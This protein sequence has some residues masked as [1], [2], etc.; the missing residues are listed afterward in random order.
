M[1]NR[2]NIDEKIGKWKKELKLINEVLINVETE[3]KSE[4]FC[5]N[6]DINDFLREVRKDPDYIKEL[7][8]QKEA[9]EYHKNLIE[10]KVQNLTLDYFKNILYQK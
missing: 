7:K 2:E 4:S 1:E 10:E 8:K 6:K 9:L 5:Y 3:I